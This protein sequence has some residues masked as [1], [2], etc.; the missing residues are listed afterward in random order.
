[1][2][3]TQDTGNPLRSQTTFQLLRGP[4]GTY[5][6]QIVYRRFNKMALGS[7]LGSARSLDKVFAR[8][9]ELSEAVH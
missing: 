9:A 4:I 5:I 8:R 2:A 3:S 1:M 7:S 6:P